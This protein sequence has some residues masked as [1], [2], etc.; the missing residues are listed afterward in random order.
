MTCA[1]ASATLPF[2]TIDTPL[3][4]G[5]ASGSSYVNF[6]W[7]LTPQP[8]T[9]PIDGSTI[10]VL[11]DGVERRH[12]RLQ[13]R[14]ADIQAL[15]PGFKNTNG[16]VGFRILDTTA[17]TNGLHTISWTVTDDQRRDRRHRQPLLHRVEQRVGGDGRRHRPRTIG[18]V[19]TSMALPARH[20]TRRRPARV[21]SGRARTDCSRPARTGMT[22]IRS[23]EVNR[24][25]LQLGRGRLPG[26][27]RTPAGLAPL[28]IG[29]RLD[30]RPTHSRGRRESVSLAATT[31]F[32]S[33]RRTAVPSRAATSASSCTRRA[34]ARSDR[35]S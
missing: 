5:A 30:P 23:E 26:Y 18:R 33:A 4:G 3:Q 16:A 24:V 13:P 34:A 29:S 19:D 7:A 32:S 10:Q 6:G 8:K 21:G 17:L 28:P 15:F 25:E 35:R 9:I 11:V 14:A 20:D 1:N 2:G 27:L 12:R 31:S 22:V